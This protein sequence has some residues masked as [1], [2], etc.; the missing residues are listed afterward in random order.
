MTNTKTLG[1][2]ARAVYEL[3]DA[4]AIGPQHAAL[5]R[6]P[7][8]ELMAAGCVRRLESGA[9]ESVRAATDKRPSSAPPARSTQPPPEPKPEPLETLVV[10]VPPAW[11]AALEAIGPS[12]SEAARAILGRAL[13]RG[14][15]TRTAVRTA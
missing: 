7:L 9:Y 1:M 14:S 6:R 3:V 12:K 10:R 5:Y 13:A 2:A 8:A 15:G 11:H 4:G